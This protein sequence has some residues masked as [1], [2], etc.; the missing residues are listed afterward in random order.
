MK[1]TVV[2]AVAGKPTRLIG[3]LAVM[4][5][6]VLTHTPIAA[7]VT[8]TEKVHETP[9]AR[10]AP[11]RLILLDAGTAVMGPPPHEPVRPLL[12]VDTISP[13][14]DPGSV[15]VQAMPVR[16]SGFAAGLVMV[17]LRAVLPKNNSTCESANDL[18]IVGGSSTVNVA[19]D[20]FPL[21]P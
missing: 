14:S 16:G 1:T 3:P 12:G 2:V 11:D 17:K 6:V 20:G 10:V 21:P 15:S 5:E 8:L 9:G 19:K 7:P 18:V 13:G 4:L